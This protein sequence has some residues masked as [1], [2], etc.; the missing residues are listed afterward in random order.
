MIIA[1]TIPLSL[2]FFRGQV[3]VLKEVFD[4]ELLSSPGPRLDAIAKEE[5][6]KVHAIPIQREISL[7]ADLKSLVKLIQLFRGLK[8]FVV[9]GNTPKGGLLTM[10]A[11]WVTSVPNRI[12]YLHGLR[13]EGTV[14]W[15]R[16]LLMT[17]ERIS[18]RC[19][20]QVFSVSQGVRKTLI[21]D[22]ICQKE[23]H[24]IWNGSVNGINT[25][26]FDPALQDVATFREE[27]DIQKEC[28]VFGFVGRLA[29]DKGINELVAAFSAIHE[30]NENTK[31]LLVGMFEEDL[32]PLQPETIV[33]IKKHPAIIHA[34]FQKDIRPFLKLMSV[35]TFP[36]YREGFGVSIMEAQAMGVPVISTNITGCN[37]IITDGQ[38]GL[39]IPP[40]SLDALTNAMKILMEDHKMRSM[41]AAAARPAMKTKYEQQKVWGETLNAYKQLVAHV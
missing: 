15:K 14:G 37:E 25:S 39:L 28:I 22:R 1:T 23:I 26:Y 40:R 19:A 36:S 29:G 5:Q 6:V 31:L 8:P 3:G 34:G 13:Y 32:D 41:M 20:T 9:H 38:N 30:M 2:M 11:A 12:Y 21:D 18:C 4:V 16:K 10:I 7:M 33:Q 24:L 35:F 17:M 27:Y